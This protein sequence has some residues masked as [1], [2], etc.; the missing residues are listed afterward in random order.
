[1]KEN[2]AKIYEI[3]PS[4]RNTIFSKEQIFPS[5]RNTLFSEEQIFPSVKNTLFS[6]ERAFP[7]VRNTI[8]SKEQIFPSVRNTLFLQEQIFPFLENPISPRSEQT[9]LS[10]FQ[11]I[12]ETQPRVANGHNGPD[13]LLSTVWEKPRLCNR[14]VT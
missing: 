3:F 7:S 11:P 13:V 12:R 8:F 9:N 2:N 14:T 4:V 1:M 5:V 6:K 10:L